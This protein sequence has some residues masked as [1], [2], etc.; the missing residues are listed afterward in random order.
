M[1]H[2]AHSRSSGV[3]GLGQPASLY[4]GNTDKPTPALYSGLLHGLLTLPPGTA[5]V[6]VMT[7]AMPRDSETGFIVI[8][9]TVDPTVFGMTNK[10]ATAVDRSHP[11]NDSHVIT[12]DW[13]G[14]PGIYFI[15]DPNSNLTGGSYM[16]D[17]TTD[18]IWTTWSA[19]NATGWLFTPPASIDY[20]GYFIV[21]C[22]AA[23][24]LD[25]IV[26]IT[27]NGVQFDV[28]R[29]DLIVRRAD[30]TCAS[31]VQARRTGDIGRLG[32][33]FLK[34]VVLFFDGASNPDLP[35]VKITAKTAHSSG[36]QVST[37]SASSAGAT[38]AL[39]TTSLLSTF[40]TAVPTSERRCS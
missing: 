19:A 2:D 8:G 11:T 12:V 7:V 37:S 25:A 10:S 26:G 15:T 9:G 16:I 34:T 30:G 6:N 33:P 32:W 28:A 31:A 21:E 18:V 39:N 40:T 20:L 38:T 3:L 13:L 29:E 23:L 27:V 4:Q 17:S 35:T 24:P 22:E 5:P 14:P 36:Q 1:S